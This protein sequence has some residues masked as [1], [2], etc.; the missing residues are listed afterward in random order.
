MA[1]RPVFIEAIRGEKL[2][3]KV[4]V[5][6]KWQ[7]G[8]SV[9]QK[10][11]SIKSLHEN[12]LKK[13]SYKGFNI[14]EVSTKSNEALGVALSAFN[15]EFEVNGKVAN[16]EAAF[17]SSKV[18]K[19][20]GPYKDLLYKGAR[21]VKGD[22]RLKN[23]G[24]VIGFEFNDR[25]WPLEPKTLFYDWIYINALL[26]NNKYIDELEKHNGFTDIEF[27]PKK[28]INCQAKALA[29]FST[30]KKRGLIDKVFKNS[31]AYI[32]FIKAFNSDKEMKQLDFFG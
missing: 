24:D 26:Q 19:E 17:Q 21:E 18:F 10:Q 32:E 1:L 2:L 7:P 15:L 30:L 29:L 27:N 13:D 28:S 12:F 11:K 4:D 20:G 8:F 5:E 3:D 16:V 6:F 31:E 25:N 23:S 22:N 14:L 9:K